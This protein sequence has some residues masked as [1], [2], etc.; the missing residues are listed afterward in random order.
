MRVPPIRRRAF[1]AALL[2]L[3]ATPTAVRAQAPGKIGRV[4][5]LATDRQTPSSPPFRAF[6]DA[7]STLGWVEGRTLLFEYRF[8]EEHVERLPELAAQLVRLNVDVI[9]APSST[10][11]RAAKHATASIPIVF[12]LHNDPV[13]TGDVSSLARPGGNITG[14]TQIATDLAPK[15]IELLREAVPGIRRLAILWNPTTPSHGPSLPVAIQ[16]AR[17]LGMDPHVLE[18][19]DLG[20]FERAYET[21]A[22]ERVNG[23]LILSSP[24]SVA[25]VTRLAQLALRHRLPTMH[26]NRAYVES[27]GL[28]SYAPIPV[29]LFRRA[30]VYVDKI[31]KGAK[32]AD[33]PVEQA[34]TFELVLNVKTAKALGLTLPPSV[35]VRADQI[36]E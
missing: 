34:T 3:G 18:A 30:A 20:Q 22:R 9:F 17:R 33:L 8:S 19:T 6:R 13:G 24:A 4:G 25:N 11:V 26:G 21:A 1:V 31:L 14:L 10:Q 2:V 7:L 29:D 12:A 35:L 36:I 5:V 15:Q 16:T 23:V 27:G 28:M 32:P